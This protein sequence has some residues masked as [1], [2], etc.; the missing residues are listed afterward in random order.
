ML[1]IILFSSSMI[2]LGEIINVLLLHISE[3]K[4]PHLLE[5]KDSSQYWLFVRE[6]WQKLT[7][8][9]HKYVNSVKARIFLSLS[10]F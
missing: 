9:F 8:I 6:L 10:L 5:D 3:V 4:F 7:T 1:L 2:C